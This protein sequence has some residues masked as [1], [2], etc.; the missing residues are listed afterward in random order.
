V[1]GQVDWLETS[2][3]EHKAAAL[4]GIIRDGRR[5]SDCQSD[6]PDQRRPAVRTAKP[7]AFLRTGVGRIAGTRDSRRSSSASQLAAGMGPVPVGD[8]TKA[9]RATHRDLSAVSQGRT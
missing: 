7:A 6:I 5:P 2:V 3:A 1:D 4:D 9:P 8:A